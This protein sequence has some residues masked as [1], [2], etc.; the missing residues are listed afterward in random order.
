MLQA[1]LIRDKNI[2]K[3]KKNQI[4]TVIK[5]K[6]CFTKI[7]SEKCFKKLKN[8]VIKISDVVSK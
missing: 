8:F 7:Y 6:F 2:F 4:E 1:R 3:I 5:K